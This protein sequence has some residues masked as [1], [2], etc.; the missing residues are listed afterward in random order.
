MVLCCVRTKKTIGVSDG[1]TKDWAIDQQ[2]KHDPVTEITSHFEPASS[3]GNF[4]KLQMY[5]E[6]FPIFRKRCGSNAIETRPASP[7]CECYSVLEVLS[8]QPAL[9]CGVTRY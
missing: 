3:G 4:R 2:L 9:S 6:H 5:S 1:K 8:D 7:E